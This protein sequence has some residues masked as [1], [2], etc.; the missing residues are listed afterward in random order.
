MQLRDVLLV[1]QG[2]GLLY[3]LGLLV[4][5]VVEVRR[6]EVR[7]VPGPSQSSRRDHVEHHTRCS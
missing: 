6:S 5:V 7:L 1:R 4:D 2:T 3:T